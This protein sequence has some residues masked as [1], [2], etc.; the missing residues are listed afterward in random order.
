MPGA[1]KSAGAFGVAPDAERILALISSYYGN[2][3]GELGG[4]GR[5][6]KEL[7]AEHRLQ[8]LPGFQVS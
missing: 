4:K 3:R 5:H 6:P 8:A 2:H 1:P 7:C